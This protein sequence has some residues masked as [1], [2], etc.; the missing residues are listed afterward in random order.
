MAHPKPRLIMR[1]PPQRWGVEEMRSTGCLGRS[2][3]WFVLCVTLVILVPVDQDLPYNQYPYLFGTHHP[4]LLPR[5]RSRIL[6]FR[7]DLGSTYIDSIFLRL[8]FV[9]W[10][11]QGNV[12]WYFL[13]T[14]DQAMQP[15]VGGGRVTVSNPKVECVRTAQ[16]S[17]DLKIWIWISR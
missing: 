9:I 10:L 11:T 3:A 17:R 12:H 6:S 14:L 5:A 8:G 1:I 2:T 4:V 15:C 16:R 7:G 13:N